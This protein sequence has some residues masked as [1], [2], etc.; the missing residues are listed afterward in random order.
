MCVGMDM[1]VGRGRDVGR[2]FGRRPLCPVLSLPI[3]STYHPSILHPPNQTD[4][5]PSTKSQMDAFWQVYAEKPTLVGAAVVAI[6][7]LEVISGIATTQGRKNGDRQ[8]GCGGWSGLW[9]LVRVR[10]P[11]R[12]VVVGQG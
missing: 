4:R 8:V 2:S 12:V 7:F 1:L 11:A 6:S 9:W 10:R 5:Q 3:Q